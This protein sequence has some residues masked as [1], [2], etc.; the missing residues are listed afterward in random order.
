MS[1]YPESV[2]VVAVTA[3]FFGYAWEE[4]PTG[5]SVRYDMHDGDV[6]DRIA[7]LKATIARLTVERD[8][9]RAEAAAAYERAAGLVDRR[10]S[11]IEVG[12]ELSGKIR[13]LATEA[14]TTAL[15]EMLDAETRACIEAYQNGIGALTARI[16]QRKEAGA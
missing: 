7:T 13:A 15:A 3:P 1:G 6:A 2:Y 12:T 16:D 9:A 5:Y 10:R 8:E 14:E 11:V 4:R